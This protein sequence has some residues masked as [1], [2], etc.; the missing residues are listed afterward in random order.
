MNS[1]LH[2]FIALIEQRAELLDIQGSKATFDDAIVRLVGW[3][4]E[5]GDLLSEDDLAVL[6][7]IGGILYRDGLR[8]RV[9][10][11]APS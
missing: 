3:I 5:K 7:E 4:D 9:P 2:P 1:D 8:R 11:H 6:G 10:P